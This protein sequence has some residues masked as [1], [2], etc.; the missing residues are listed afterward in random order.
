[1]NIRR[2]D[3]GRVSNATGDVIHISNAN[4]FLKEM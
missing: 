4:V 2:N 1:M 3:I